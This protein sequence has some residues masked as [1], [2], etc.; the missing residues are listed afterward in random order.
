M[1][2]ISTSNVGT[3]YYLCYFDTKSLL[4]IRILLQS[5]KASVLIKEHSLPNFYKETD[6]EKRQ[7]AVSGEAD[8]MIPPR[9]KPS[10]IASVLSRLQR[11]LK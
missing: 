7:H 11:M 5:V 2:Q 1:K 10:D 9:S 8:D 6:D 3:K 4:G